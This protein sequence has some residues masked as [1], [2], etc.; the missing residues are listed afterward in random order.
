MMSVVAVPIAT[1]LLYSVTVEFGC[2][3]PVSVGVV[4]SVA[5]PLVKL[6]VRVPT[7]SSIVTITGAFGRLVNGATTEALPPTLPALSVANASRDS[8]LVCGGEIVTLKLPVPSAVAVP[9]TVP[10]LVVIVTVLPA[11]AIPVTCVP[12]VI[13]ASVVGRLG[14][15]VSTTTEEIDD[16]ALVLPAVSVAVAVKLCWPLVKMVEVCGSVQLPLASAV[17]VPTSVLPS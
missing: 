8:P 15:R 14:A 11:S 10:P 13:T 17:T 9:S 4:S 5:F 2:A 1:P 7:L 3:V 6:P 16:G 12:L